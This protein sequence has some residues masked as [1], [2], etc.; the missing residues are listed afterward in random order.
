MVWN[1]RIAARL[2]SLTDPQL[3]ADMS[4]STSE[5]VDAAVRWGHIP[6]TRRRQP[7]RGGA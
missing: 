3:T 6:V 7:K 1:T 2:V 5:L 4:V